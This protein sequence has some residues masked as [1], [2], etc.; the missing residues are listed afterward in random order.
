VFFLALGNAIRMKCERARMYMRLVP[1][2]CA[3]GERTHTYRGMVKVM[4][5]IAC[6]II[7]NI[8]ALV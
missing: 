8:Y 4:G 6:Q 3:Y 7:C 1:R 5:R 2:M